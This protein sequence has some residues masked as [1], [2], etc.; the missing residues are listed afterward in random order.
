[1]FILNWHLSLQAGGGSSG[2]VM[3]V[4]FGETKPERLAT[5]PNCGSSEQQGLALSPPSVVYV[6]APGVGEQQGAILAVPIS[7]GASVV[8]A[9]TNGASNAVVADS[10]NAYFGDADGVK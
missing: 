2:Y 3:K 9:T 10:E 8:L 7:G 1:Y 4:T 6:Q 5:I